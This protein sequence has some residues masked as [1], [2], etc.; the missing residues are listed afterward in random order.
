MIFQDHVTNGFSNLV[1]GKVSHH[2]AK[3]DG[4]MH[5]SIRDIMVLVCHMISQ[6][7]NIKGSCDSMGIILSRCVTILQSGSDM[8]FFIVEGQNS[9]C[10][11]LNLLLLFIS[12]A[13]GMPCSQ[14]QNFRT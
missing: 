4:H 3:F 14:I 9:T 5:C 12:K 11:R 10:P 13:H 6:D 1:G 8:I 7:H 2:P